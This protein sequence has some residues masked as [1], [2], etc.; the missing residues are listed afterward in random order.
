MKLIRHEN[1]QY[2]QSDLLKEHGFI[3]AF[4]T[5]NH[6]NNEPKE[7]QKYMNLTS[8]IHYLKQIHSNKIIQ[9]NN[10]LELKNKTGDCLI[11]KEKYQSLWI[12]TADCI[13]IIIA[14][15]KTRS[16]A[17][18]HSG[19]EGLKKGI[20]SKTLKR[21]LS[22]GSKINN[23]I[24]A[25]GPSIKGDKYQLK[26]KDV[27]TLIIQ[28]TGKNIS[29]A[30][31]YTIEWSKEETISLFKKDSLYDSLLFDIKAAAILQL[32]K[33]GIRKSQININSSCTFSNPE[34][35]NSFRR[36]NTNL[37]QWSCIYS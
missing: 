4:F 2:F 3:H 27:D 22:I 14:D 33:E 18:C 7:L 29:E 8:N 5:R 25:I 6:E 17:A 13:P 19:L 9:I 1:I 26:I 36:D 30:D 28:L 37:R 35:F 23:I 32:A 31:S 10:H 24:V 34:L 11:T 12:Y 16:I 21:F 20:I 15:T